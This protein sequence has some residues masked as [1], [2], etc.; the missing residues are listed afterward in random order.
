MYAYAP[1]AFLRKDA[2]G[3]ID[4]IGF[5]LA[6]YDGDILAKAYHPAVL[7]SPVTLGGG[8]RFILKKQGRKVFGMT[9]LD[10]A[11]LRNMMDAAQPAGEGLLMVLLAQKKAL[12]KSRSGKVRFEAFWCDMNVVSAVVKI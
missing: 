1:A 2:G 12:R 10:D 6:L 3:S 9:F 8:N 5:G 7:H 11:A 4:G